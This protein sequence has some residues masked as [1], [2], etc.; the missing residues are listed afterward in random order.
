[1]LVAL[2]PRSVWNRSFDQLVVEQPRLQVRR[3]PGGKLHV[4]GLDLSSAGASG[5][6]LLDWFFSQR[7][8][9][10]QGGSIDWTDELRVAPTLSLRQ[11]QL[12]LR[13]VGRRHEL[14]LD[15]TP[16]TACERAF[17]ATSFVCARRTLADLGW[18]VLQR[19]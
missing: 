8:W 1:V 6:A 5:Q 14:R 10:V 16:P 2:S 9:V 3:D 17:S 4:A 18:P 7:E 12:V 19:F 15:A 11:V 13:N